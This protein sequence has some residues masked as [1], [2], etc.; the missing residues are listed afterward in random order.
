[1]LDGGCVVLFWVGAPHRSV[2]SLIARDDHML[3]IR[4]IERSLV[5]KGLEIQVHYTYPVT[6]GTC[7]PIACLP[8][9][10]GQIPTIP[11]E[12][13]QTIVAQY[14][15]VTFSRIYQSESNYAASSSPSR[16]T[17]CF[18]ACTLRRELVISQRHRELGWTQ[19]DNW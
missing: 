8:S 19:S 18:R 13:C 5:S 4:Q 16:C 2:E 17:M 6:Q 12:E 7:T 10:E 9:Q 3:P 11:Y 14:R 1:V 15:Y